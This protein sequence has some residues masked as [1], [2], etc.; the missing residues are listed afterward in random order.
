MS[1]YWV[2]DLPNW[3]FGGL[4]V[5]VF[6]LFSV[7]GLLLLRPM[8]RRFF[9][10]PPGLNDLVSYFLSATGVFYGITLGLISVGTWQ[11][12]SDVDSKVSREA[13]AVASLFTDINAFEEPSRTKLRGL[14]KEYTHYTI[15]DA[16]PQQQRGQV[17]KGGTERMNA[18]FAEIVAYQP[19][20]PSH[21]SLQAEAMRQFNH[22]VELRRLRLQSVNQGLPPV[23]WGVVFVGAALNLALTWLFSTDRIGGHILL[24]ALLGALVGL[25]VFLMAA[26]DNPFRGEFSVSAE[27]FEIIY[28]RIMVAN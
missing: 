9:G 8:V 2:Y 15:Y 18:I 14:V 4:M 16:W 20:T 19:K 25:L 11:N 27:A 26:M 10:P 23:L 5:A 22:V 13:A 21:E 24:V 28:S 3:V 1:F 7:A 12:Y 6:M 17:P